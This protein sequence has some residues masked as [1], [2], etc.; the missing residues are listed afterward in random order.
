M[1][2]LPI[3]SQFPLRVVT[4]GRLS[5]LQWM[6]P[7]QGIYGKH[8]LDSQEVWLSPRGQERQFIEKIYTF[9]V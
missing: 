7:Y 4:P 9:T 3:T 8:K 1:N 5:T 2:P 6:A